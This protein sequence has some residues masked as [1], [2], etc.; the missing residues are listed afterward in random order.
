MDTPRPCR[1]SGGPSNLTSNLRRSLTC[2]PLRCPNQRGNGRGMSLPV[3]PLVVPMLSAGEEHGLQPKGKR[4]IMHSQNQIQY[5][6]RARY[7]R[8]IL[9]IRV[10]H[11]VSRRVFRN[12]FTQ[13]DFPNKS[14]YV[15]AKTLIDGISKST[16]ISVHEYGL[17]CY[18]SLSGADIPSFAL[19]PVR[20]ADGGRIGSLV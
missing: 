16:P 12:E 9:V 20:E 19:R 18:L 2:G 17:W 1:A 14:I 15:I 6:I 8:S 11:M 3:A 13:S 4:E 7:E 5:T 10:C